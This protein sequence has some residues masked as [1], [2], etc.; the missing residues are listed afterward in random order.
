MNQLAERAIVVAER[1]GEVESVEA[2][3][4]KGA[5]AALVERE[6]VEERRAAGGAEVLGGEWLDRFE[7]FFADGDAREIGE[8]ESAYAAIVG[9]YEAEKR[10]AS[11]GRIR[12]DCKW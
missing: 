9:E 1:V 11:A 4:A 2:L 6:F 12:P 3:A 8:R 5:N 7:A 10:R